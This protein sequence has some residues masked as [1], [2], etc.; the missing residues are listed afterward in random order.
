MNIKEQH[1]QILKAKLASLKSKEQIEDVDQSVAEVMKVC[2][3]I[4]KQNM[5]T[6]GEHNLLR[7]G[8]QLL[9]HYANIGVTT[10][11]KR[12]ERDAHEQTYEEM[13]SS[14]TIMYKSS[15]TGITEARSMAK[16]GLGEFSAA[17]IE[18]EQV[19][20]AYEAISEATKMTIMFLQSAIRVKS[21]ERV[22]TKFEGE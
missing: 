11:L 4:Y 16:N 13:L 12:A 6:L 21:T 15:D 2:R 9:G 7:Y 1:N 14:L 17:V 22:N 20:K 18:A 10:S 8:G 5:D 19:Y 3:E